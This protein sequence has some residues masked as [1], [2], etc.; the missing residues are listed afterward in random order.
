MDNHPNN[1]ND[2]NQQNFHNQDTTIAQN[3]YSQQ[4][5]DQS[6]QQKNHM[7]NMWVWYRR[8]RA[9]PKLGI[10]CGALVILMMGC[11]VCSA[12]VAGVSGASQP[13]TAQVAVQA[14]TPPKPAT[15]PKPTPT[16]S[17]KLTPKPSPKPTPTPAQPTPMPKPTPTPSS[18]AYTHATHGPAVLGGSV[19]NFFG[20]YG[21]ATTTPVGRGYTWAV[22]DQDGNPSQLVSAQIHTDGTV[23]RVDVINSTTTNWSIAQS[24]Q[25]CSAFLPARPN[26]EEQ[27]TDQITQSSSLAGKIQLDIMNDQGDCILQ[28]SKTIG[29][30]N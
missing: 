29:A 18:P 4:P 20:K 19:S 11:F 5:P 3:L 9:L 8:Q 15:T 6:P 23:Y 10:G 27:V 2:P 7:K 14:T 24:T 13:T 17:P 21:N 26:F 1:P 22:N 30:N 12:A 28:F 25:I 16:P